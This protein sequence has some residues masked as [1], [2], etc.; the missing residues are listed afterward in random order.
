[1]WRGCRF[2]LCEIEE[3]FEVGSMSWGLVMMLMR[4]IVDSK[5]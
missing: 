4:G 3:N 2:C 5:P 1:M